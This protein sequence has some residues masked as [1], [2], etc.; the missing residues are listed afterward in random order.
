MKKKLFENNAQNHDCG[1]VIQ[2]KISVKQSMTLP[3]IARGGCTERVR[4]G[5]ELILAYAI[6]G[7]NNI[8][9]FEESEC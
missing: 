6:F 5:M 4:F 7:A 8:Y 3:K 9:F 2:K 1:S